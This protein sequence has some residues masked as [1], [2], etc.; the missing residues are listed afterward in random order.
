MV[1]I[2]KHPQPTKIKPH[3][4]IMHIAIA[5]S[6]F[7]FIAAAITF[8]MPRINAV[9]AAVAGKEEPNPAVIRFFS[10]LSLLFTIA[11]LLLVF[12]YLINEL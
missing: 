9:R 12:Y 5:Y 11:G 8:I 7:Y 1:I 4:P 2:T 10:W 3:Q 6:I